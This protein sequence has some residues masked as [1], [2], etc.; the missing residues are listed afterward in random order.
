MSWNCIECGKQSLRDE[1][2]T[3][4]KRCY[5]CHQRIMH[6]KGHRIQQIKEEVGPYV[7]EV[8]RSS[9]EKCPGDRP[10]TEQA[11]VGLG[12]LKRVKNR[13][14]KEHFESPEYLVGWIM[15]DGSVIPVAFTTNELE[16]PLA[17]A[18]RNREDLKVLEVRP[19]DWDDIKELRHE[20]DDLKA[21]EEALLSRGLLARIFNTHTE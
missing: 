8:L 12:E 14:V 1:P 18:Q 13:E 7:E 11:A 4:D 16:R 19:P 10:M 5:D 20:I 17:R 21:R 2:V 6:Q 3:F 15:L 9:L